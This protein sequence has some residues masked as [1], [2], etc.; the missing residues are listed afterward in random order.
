MLCHSLD[1]DIL[2]SYDIIAVC[3]E[4]SFLVQEVAALIGSPFMDHRYAQPLLLAVVTAFLP[5]RSFSLC[6]GQS[7]FGSSQESRIT[8]IVLIRSNIQAVHRK[9]QTK[10]S[11]WYHREYLVF[12]LHKDADVVLS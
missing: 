2:N 5:F 1:A 9:I 7:L 12:I 4:T 6:L 10:K 11:L 3:Q 8:S